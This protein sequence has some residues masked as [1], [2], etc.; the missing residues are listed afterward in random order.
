M[1]A[2]GR[3]SASAV[4]LALGISK[5]AAFRHLSAMRE[6]GVAE[7]AGTGRGAGWRLAPRQED[8]RR[9]YT[10]IEDLAQA[11]HDGLVEA[12]DEQRAVLE[13]ALEIARRPRL[14]LLQGGGGGGQ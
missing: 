12:D 10:T 5:T 6:H 8:T 9:E 13:Q 2:S 14:T 7:Q 3:T 4:G 11:V 1:L